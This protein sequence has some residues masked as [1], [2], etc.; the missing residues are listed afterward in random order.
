MTF[1]DKDGNLPKQYP[2]FREIS[3]YEKGKQEI[4]L[5]EADVNEYTLEWSSC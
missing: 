3:K 2:L 5:H 1:I 4:K